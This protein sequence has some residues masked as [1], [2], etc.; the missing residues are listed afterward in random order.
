MNDVFAQQ[1]PDK[2]PNNKLIPE[3]EKTEVTYL[4]ETTEDKHKQLTDKAK[5]KWISQ[6]YHNIRY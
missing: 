1:P 2:I 6:S 4:Q 3:D 5:K